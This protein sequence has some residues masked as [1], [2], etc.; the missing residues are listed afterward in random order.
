M[1]KQ[2]AAVPAK[3]RPWTRLAKKEQPFRFLD[4]PPELRN[5]VYVHLFDGS[6]T[7]LEPQAPAIFPNLYWRFTH[8]PAGKPSTSGLPALLAVN[9]QLRNEAMNI[10][11]ASTEWVIRDHYHIKALLQKLGP[12][13]VA[14]MRSLCYV[15]ERIPGEPVEISGSS[16]ATMLR[17]VLR[18]VGEVG[19]R[20]VMRV[21]VREADGMV[22]WAM[23]LER[24]KKVTWGAGYENGT[25]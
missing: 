1:A 16:G 21:E 20:S 14:Q 17:W 4:L 24:D 12:Q 19:N 7:T 10:F 22:V 11:Y 9:K 23:G 15:V 25:G 8:Q 6:T 2:K 5:T 13:R 3:S 18:E